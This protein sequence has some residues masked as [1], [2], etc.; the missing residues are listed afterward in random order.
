MS[1]DLKSM[2][3][4]AGMWQGVP[5]FQLIPVTEDCPYVEAVFMPQNKVLCIISKIKEDRLQMIDRIDEKGYRTPI[6]GQK[7]P[8]TGEQIYKQQ[9]ITINTYHDYYIL[10]PPEMK[11]FIE[12]FAINSDGYPYGQLI[13]MAINM[14]N[15]KAQAQT[16]AKGNSEA[17]VETETTENTVDFKKAKADLDQ[18]PDPETKE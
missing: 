10:T 14:S 7:N 18:T 15:M 6:V 17:K 16:E 9:R 13:D 11:Y 8:E 4:C 12:T 5:T 2:M 1:K 3:L